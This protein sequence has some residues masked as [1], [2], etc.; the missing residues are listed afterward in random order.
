MDH[1]QDILKSRPLLLLILPGM[2]KTMEV[3]LQKVILMN[4][5]A[6]TFFVALH[7]RMAQFEIRPVSGFSDVRNESPGH[8]DTADITVLAQSKTF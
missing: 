2:H 1:G 7:A 6:V 4:I 5:Q 3:F 8:G